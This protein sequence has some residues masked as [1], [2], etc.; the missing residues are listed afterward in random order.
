MRLILLLSF[1]MLL[2]SCV[3]RMGVEPEI[4]QIVRD[5]DA[6]KLSIELEKG[7]D[8]NMVNGVGDPLVYVAAGPKGGLDVLTL[9]LNA[10]ADPNSTNSVGRTALHNAAGWCSTDLVQTLIDRGANPYLKNNKGRTAL[11][12]TCSAPE[13]SRQQVVRDLREAMS[14]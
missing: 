5:N 7:A 12:A 3:Q 2:S 14:R 1:V 10:G 13:S 11:E 4:F 9:L 8:P 6:L